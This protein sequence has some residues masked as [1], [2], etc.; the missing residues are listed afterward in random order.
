MNVRLKKTPGMC[1][2]GP[3]KGHAVT[4]IRC[5]GIVA[6][7]CLLLL[8]SVVGCSDEKACPVEKPQEARKRAEA[9]DDR[10]LMA[11]SDDV[12]IPVVLSGKAAPLFANSGAE[13]RFHCYGGPPAVSR[14]MPSN[15]AGGY[16][17]LL[18][19][20]SSGW[21]AMDVLDRKGRRLSWI[22]VLSEKTKKQSISL[23]KPTPWIEV[24]QDKFDSALNVRFAPEIMPGEIRWTS[25]PCWNVETRELTE[26]KPPVAT[27]AS[28]ETPKQ[29]LS[30]DVM[31]TDCWGIWWSGYFPLSEETTPGD[32]FV[33]TVTQDT[34]DLF[35][36]IVAR[37]EVIVTTTRH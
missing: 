9:E 12:L 25:L 6:A 27:I 2:M 35:G 5:T 31:D 11:N 32:K 26:A 1:F 33:V 16:V 36:C 14:N 24:R 20:T 4:P 17:T 34:G 29:I 7:G 3:V 10:E 8:L 22:L 21:C 28:A 37:K 30:R 19:S 13:L 18:P 23:D 15:L